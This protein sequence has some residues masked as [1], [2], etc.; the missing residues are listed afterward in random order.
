MSAVI[1]VNRERVNVSKILLA[2][3]SDTIMRQLLLASAML[4]GMSVP[5]AAAG[6][7]TVIGIG[8]YSCG[9]W[10][11]DRSNASEAYSD[12]A[13]VTGFLSGVGWTADYGNPGGF[14]D[15]NGVVAWL[16]RFCSAY[17]TDHI[18][19]AAAAFVRFTQGQKP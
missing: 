6:T 10:T 5:V 9:T 7:Y 3:A 11:A 18:A 15:Y 4:V 2:R 1:T 13:W 16:D 19:D 12:H 8:L 14:T 17:P